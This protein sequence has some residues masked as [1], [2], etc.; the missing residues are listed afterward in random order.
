MSPRAAVTTIFFLNGAVFS[1]WYAR[2]PAIQD[3]IGLGT[4]AL[5]V[6]LLGAPAGLLAAQPLVGAALARRGSRAAVAAA[7][8]YVPAVVLPAL[9]GDAVTLFVA[10]TVVGAVNGTLDIA[11][12]AQGLAV[13]RSER[14]RIFNSLH[15]GFSFGAMAGAG[16]A[17]AVAALGIAP[18]PHLIGVAVVGGAAATAV[19]PSLLDD[20]GS[21]DPR[22]P[23]FARPSARLAALGTIAFCALLAEGAVFDWSGVF[24]ATEAGA[25]AGIAPL[26]L[27]A[28]SLAMGAG[29]LAADPATERAGSP[30]VAA[31]GALCAALGLGL[32]L[33]L[34]APAG[35]VLGFAV[36][37]LGLSAV[38]PL[39]LRASGL[40]GPSS[41][42]ALAAVSTVGYSGFLLGPPVIGLLAEATSLRSALVLVC[43][44]CV[45]AA[46]LAGHVRE[47]TAHPARP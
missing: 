26:G 7:P 38:F 1:S 9:A 18:L 24:L 32:A 5:G 25:A 36:M 31:T 37:G 14:R 46:A 29:R 41:A 35:A 47:A 20:S 17:G 28:F 42:P 44:L 40:E 2:L 30:G 15:A 39:A 13:E 4:G 19:A 10:V 3:D 43:A 22:A 27:A 11:M 33:A 6:A 8:V 34:A 23:R 12:N 21:A 45:L 16:L